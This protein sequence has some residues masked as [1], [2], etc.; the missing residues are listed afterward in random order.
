M[1]FPQLTV[2]CC[3]RYRTIWNAETI[4][5]C[6]VHPGV[7]YA[8]FSNDRNDLVKKRRKAIGRA[9]DR[10]NEAIGAPASNL[11]CKKSAA[12]EA[13]PMVVAQTAAA[14]SAFVLDAL[15]TSF[16]RWER[17]IVELLTVAQQEGDLAKGEDIADLA[18]VI[19][20]AYEG[21]LIRVKVKGDVS[22]F[23]RFR[24][25]GLRR[26]LGRTKPAFS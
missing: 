1:Q 8:P 16:D 18:A 5:Q 25:K 3:S 17:S 22:A 11:Y 4:A 20:E 2:V 7:E 13:V 19:V 6:F 26:L 24:S 10:E 15:A 21:A 23:T 12:S 14:R 9:V